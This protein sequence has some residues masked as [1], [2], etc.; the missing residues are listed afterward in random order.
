MLRDG[1]VLKTYLILKMNSSNVK[2]KRR[3]LYI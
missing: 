3:A 1:A 2:R